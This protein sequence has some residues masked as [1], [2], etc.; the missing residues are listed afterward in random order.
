MILWQHDD[1][2]VKFMPLSLR[3]LSRVQ[4]CRLYEAGSKK[5]CCIRLYGQTY[6]AC[7]RTRIITLPNCLFTYKRTLGTIYYDCRIMRLACDSQDRSCSHVRARYTWHNCPVDRLLTTSYGR[8][9]CALRAIVCRAHA[10]ANG[11]RVNTSVRCSDSIN[12]LDNSL[13]R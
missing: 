4:K 5:L 2:R 1:H 10:R 9:A 13:D 7:I 3:L 6:I 12:G 8:F 11:I